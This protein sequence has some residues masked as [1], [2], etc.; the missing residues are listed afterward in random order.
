MFALMMFGYLYSL[1]NEYHNQAIENLMEKQDSIHIEMEPTK[2]RGEEGLNW[3]AF[4]SPQKYKSA[5]LRVC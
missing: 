1:L 2:G 3:Y 5:R 4:I